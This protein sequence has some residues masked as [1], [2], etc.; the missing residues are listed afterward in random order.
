MDLSDRR[1]HKRLDLKLDMLCQ[2]IGTDNS[3]VSSG[4]TINIS[5][6]GILAK[7]SHNKFEIGDLVNVQMTVPPTDGLLDYGGRME[8]YARVTRINKL[9]KT[10]AGKLVALEFCHPPKLSV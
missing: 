3:A 9:T 7:T 2:R 10:D 5:T 8:G 4:R 1:K 6:G